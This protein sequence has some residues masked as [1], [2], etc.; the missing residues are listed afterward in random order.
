MPEPSGSTEARCRLVCGAR[1][2]TSSSSCPRCGRTDEAQVST[3]AEPSA[4]AIKAAHRAIYGGRVPAGDEVMSRLVAE[5]AARETLA[6][7]APAIH[8]AGRAKGE[9]RIE[10]LLTHVHRIDHIR[11]PQD[12][13]RRCA[14]LRLGLPDTPEGWRAAERE[15]ANG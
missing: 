9:A 15:T 3:G 14:A 10:A 11:G 12:S 13:C 2:E 8:A 4:E 7:D 1:K 6:I 5:T